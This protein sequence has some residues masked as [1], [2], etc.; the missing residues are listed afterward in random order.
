[1]KESEVEKHF[2]WT[3]ERLGGKTYKFRSVTQRG[4]FDRIACL[5]SGETWFVELKTTGGRLSALQKFFLL[6]MQHLKD[7]KSTRLNSSHVSESRMPSSA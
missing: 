3:V 2:D 1:M 6:T 4:V 7:R 5:P